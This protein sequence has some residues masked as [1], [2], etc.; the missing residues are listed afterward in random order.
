MFIAVS[1]FMD[2]GMTFIDHYYGNADYSYMVVGIDSKQA[3]TIEKCPKSK[4]I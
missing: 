1:A 4:I 2:Y 3:Q